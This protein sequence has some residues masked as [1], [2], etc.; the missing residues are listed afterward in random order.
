[1]LA[2]VLTRAP[3]FAQTGFPETIRF[4]TSGAVRQKAVNDNRAQAP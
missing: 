3:L 1:M 4:D 2:I